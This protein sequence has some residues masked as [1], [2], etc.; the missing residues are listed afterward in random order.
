MR[1]SVPGVA[2]TAARV[3]LIR[4]P[5]EGDGSRARVSSATAC[6][7]LSPLFAVGGFA[8]GQELTEGLS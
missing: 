7:P 5:V 2:S 6:S 4:E 8:G 1:S 3:P